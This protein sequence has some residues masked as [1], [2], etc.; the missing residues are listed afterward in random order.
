[1]LCL[2]AQ[3]WNAPTIAKIFDCHQHTVRA[4]LRRW[5]ERGLGGL[6]EAPGRGAKAKWQE[7]DLQYV[8][9]CLENEPRT[10]SSVQLA[11]KFKQERL[12]DLSGDR[13]RR[14]LKKRLSL[15]TNEKKSEKQA[16]PPEKGNQA[17]RFSFVAP[18]GSR[19]RN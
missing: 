17:G 16:R 5:Q 10:Y 12:V 19:E 4:T 11:K 8:A 18:G 9:D 2:N 13:L 14:L 15:E 7:A 3:G 1:M 6:W